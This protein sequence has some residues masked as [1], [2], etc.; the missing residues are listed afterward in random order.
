MGEGAKQ[1]EV[2]DK[3]MC[4]CK[5]AG[6][7]LQGSIDG[8]NTKIPQVA[9]SIKEAE[10][11]KAQLELELKEHQD[12]RADAKAA[13]AKATALRE[14]EASAFLKQSTEYKTN[15]AAL[16]SAITAI[17][18][19]MSG[20]F[21]Q[22]TTAKTVERL[23][24]DLG[25]MTNYDRQVLVSFLSG[26]TTDEYAPQSGQ[27][28][29]ILKEMEETMSKDLADITA[30]EEGSKQTYGE[31]MDAKTKEVVANTRAIES[32]TARVG[33]LGVEIAGMK[34]DLSDTEEQ[35][36]DDKEFLVN[37]DATCA[38]KK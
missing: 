32:K 12:S 3:Y 11:N 30:T 16:R 27:I 17:E 38:T 26:K 13:K 18:N 14:R 23:A 31:L 19:G 37:M 22:G 15:I 33:N 21:L 28:T 25:D 8:A 2:H 20:S 35:L 34:N 6:S 29:G 1:K 9:S 36:L 5:T 24:I 7:T 4:Y 10:S